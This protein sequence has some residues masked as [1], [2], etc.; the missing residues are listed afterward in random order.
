M[1]V[2]TSRSRLVVP[3]AIALAV[4]CAVGTLLFPG[5]NVDELPPVEKQVP[6]RG[7]SV[8]A[9]IQKPPRLP[10]VSPAEN[11]RPSE[12]TLDLADLHASCPSIHDVVDV[13]C[14]AA[15]DEYFLDRPVS[16]SIL[17]VADAPVWRD[18]FDDPGSARD[19]TVKTLA[20]GICDVANGEIRQDLGDDCDARSMVE[21][22][23]LLR[24]CSRDPGRYAT[25]DYFEQLLSRIEHIA[26]N[27]IYWQRRNAIEEDV[28]RSAWLGERCAA[29]AVDAL[30]PLYHFEISA[31]DIYLSH[32][33]HS[34][35]PD[36]P[37][38]EYEVDSYL[39][40]E[41]ERLIEMAARLGD[42]W[43]LS[44]FRGDAAH[45][46]RV[47]RFN[48]T[49]AYL[50]EAE[51][52]VEQVWRRYRREHFDGLSKAEAER[53]R[54]VD[55]RYPRIV[56]GMEWSQARARALMSG[57][58]AEVRRLESQDPFAGL[59]DDELEDLRREDREHMDEG[60]AVHDEFNSMRAEI[61]ARAEHDERLVRLTYAMIV[62]AE[63]KSAGMVVDVMALYERAA[64]FSSA[65]SVSSVS[66]VLPEDIRV[67]RER[68]SAILD[69]RRTEPDR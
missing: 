47:F 54:E 10:H 20:E 19:G 65:S 51:L 38:D 67:A 4:A 9:P 23:V 55:R 69:S 21:Q 37:L 41:A 6:V 17:T 26:D 7:E 63:A 42:A 29:V 68:A 14:L 31:D 43:A 59:N 50:H 39:R 12:G 58:H 49:Q 22:A 52:E 61:G 16:S 11:A 32:P 8:A 2:T 30:A 13:G 5:A 60:L 25:Y 44:E 64:P 1:A 48:P 34:Y 33:P 57:D 56:A 3:G 40:E 28:F 15:L 35:Y 18:V 66:S 36:R 53:Q 45:V 27:S 24:E 62:E 46:E